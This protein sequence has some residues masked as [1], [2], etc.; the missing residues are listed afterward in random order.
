[1]GRVT[2]CGRGGDLVSSSKEGAI[3]GDEKQDWYEDLEGSS[4]RPERRYI[5]THKKNITTHKKI[6][7]SLLYRCV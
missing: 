6:S 3:V 7:H 2:G 4:Y 1:M 5:T